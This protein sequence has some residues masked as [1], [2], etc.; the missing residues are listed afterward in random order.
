MV[1]ILSCAVTFRDIFINLRLLVKFMH[2]CSGVFFS[3]LTHWHFMKSCC[4]KSHDCETSKTTVMRQPGKLLRRCCLKLWIEDY[5]AAC[6][7]ARVSKV[8]DI[9][10][11]FLWFLH[12]SLLQAHGDF[13]R[14]RQYKARRSW[15]L[16]IR[17]EE[18]N[19]I[20]TNR[21]VNQN[22]KLFDAMHRNLN[23]PTTTTAVV[24][25]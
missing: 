17:P 6:K 15:S 11:V 14:N 2:R 25:M 22:Q 10:T 4:K 18:Y 24:E 7:A 13:L 16:K 19:H 3:N 5:F 8:W 20:L 12:W 21:M 9:L 23:C 1:R